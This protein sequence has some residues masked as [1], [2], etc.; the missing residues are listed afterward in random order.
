MGEHDDELHHLEYGK[1]LLPTHM[2]ALNGRVIVARHGHVND[3]VE[4]AKEEQV[5]PVALETD[6]QVASSRHQD[7]M[8]DMH[9]GYLPVLLAEHKEEGIQQV[10][11]LV[12][13]VGVGDGAFPML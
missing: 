10:H 11:D 12:D 6:D 4:G 3:D 8:E 9:K 5:A 2:I 1:V 13:V 7:V